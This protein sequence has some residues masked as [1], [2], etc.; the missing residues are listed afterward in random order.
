MKATKYTGTG[1][2]NQN[3]EFMMYNLHLF[4]DFFKGYRNQTFKFEFTLIPDD[5][6]SKLNAYYWAELIPKF[7]RALLLK[8]ET[9]DDKETHEYLRKLCPIMRLYQEEWRIKEAKEYCYRDITDEG[10]GNIDWTEYVRQL[11]QIA[12]EHFYIVINDPQIQ[13][14]E[15]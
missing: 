11:I 12:A 9:L 3:E 1:V 4:K 6:S 5:D 13:A 8:G 7:R 15:I 14:D 2:V 10:W